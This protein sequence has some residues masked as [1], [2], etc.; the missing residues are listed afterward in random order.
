MKLLDIYTRESETHIKLVGLVEQANHETV[1][2]FFEFPV[3]Y[4]T[5][6]NVTADPF[7]PLLLIPAMYSG[8]DLE[9]QHDISTKLITSIEII[10]DIFSSWY[11]ESFRKVKVWGY[12]TIERT[13]SS[14][15]SG[16]F[17]SLGVDSFYT[18]LKNRD[19]DLRYLVYM[20]GLELPLSRYTHNQEYGVVENIKNVCEHY[21]LELITGQTNFRDHFQL[22]WPKFYHGAGLASV[23]LA[24]SGGI[25]RMYIASSHSYDAH[26]PVGSSFMLDHYWSTEQTEIV[27]DGAEKGRGF[28]LAEVVA[29]DPYALNNLRVCTEND[30]GDYN[31]C[32][33]RKCVMTMAALDIIGKLDDSRV[34]PDKSIKGK[35]QRIRPYSLSSYI[36]VRDL[37][38]L[39][40]KYGRFDL[41]KEI[42]KELI[43]GFHDL[44]GRK[45]MSYGLGRYIRELLFYLYTKLS[46]RLFSNEQ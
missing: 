31:C 33:C 13:L 43:V 27:H 12:K 5:F 23:A 3:A 32:H 2:L 16:Q 28:K 38:T 9:I 22:D 8:E 19:K 20:Q 18:L 17:F 25:A 30:G 34:F 45:E 36:L 4:K 42:N 6:I 21:E 40:G 29:H 26:I 41:V 1:E 46:R 14:G 39:A 24:L 7:L 11:P 44:Y 10:Q 37:Q 15:Y 35:I